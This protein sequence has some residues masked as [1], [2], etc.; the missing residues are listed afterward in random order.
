[1]VEE[2]E[3]MIIKKGRAK[4]DGDCNFCSSEVRGYERNQRVYIV[5]AVGHGPQLQ[6]RFCKKHAEQ[7]K[8]SIK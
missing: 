8:K 3:K 7:F 2:E 5:Q 6:V 1:M 4:K